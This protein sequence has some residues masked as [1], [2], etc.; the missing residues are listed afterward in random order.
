M[1]GRDPGV[2]ACLQEAVEAAR[3]LNRLPPGLELKVIKVGDDVF[4]LNN[5]TLLVAQQANLPHVS[6]TDVRGSGLNQFNKLTK[7]AGPLPAGE[8]PRIRG[9]K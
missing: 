5:R 9:C 7:E 3:A 4:A 8:Q 2:R 1:P 6:P